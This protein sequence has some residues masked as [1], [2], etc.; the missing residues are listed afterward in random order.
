MSWD[1]RTL[2]W[3][4]A[5]FRLV[6]MTKLRQASPEEEHYW[7]LHAEAGLLTELS[8][9]DPGVG[10]L[11]GRYLEDQERYAAEVDEA[12]RMVQFDEIFKKKDEGNG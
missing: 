10:M 1:G 4:Q 12:R 6:E 2:A 8:N 7:Q 11:A 5:W 3:L 9:A